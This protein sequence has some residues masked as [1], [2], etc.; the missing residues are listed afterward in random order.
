[1]KRTSWPLA[2]LLKD[3][4]IVFHIAG[5]NPPQ[6]APDARL[7]SLWRAGQAKERKAA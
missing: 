3:G 5:T 2:K 7:E 4:S 6:Y 1:M